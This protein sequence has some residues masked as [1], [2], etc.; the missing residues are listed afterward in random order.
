MKKKRI[1]FKKIRK[2]KKIEHITLDPAP[3]Y[4]PVERLKRVN[5]LIQIHSFLN[6]SFEI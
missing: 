5:K 4:L 2:M 1:K 6:D 3:W